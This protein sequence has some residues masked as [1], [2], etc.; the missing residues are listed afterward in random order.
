MNNNKL[1]WD[2]LSLDWKVSLIENLMGDIN[3]D[4]SG[5]DKKELS[6]ELILERFINSNYSI[7]D[8]LNLQSLSINYSLA[9]DLTPVFKLQQ[10]NDFYIEYPNEKEVNYGFTDFIYIYPKQLRAKVKKLDFYI[11]KYIK[12]NLETIKDFVNLREI[13]F[14]NCSI[15]S[16]AGIQNLK[17]LEKVTIDQGNSFNDLSPL[18]ELKLKYLDI[19]FSNVSDLNPLIGMPLET[20]NIKETPIE[21]LSPLMQ[22]PTLQHLDFSN[23]EV[24]YDNLISKYLSNHPS[25]IDI[26]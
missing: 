5:N 7:D 3:S 16:L 23:S 11:P 9:I 20:L 24:D 18:K 6:S 12:G 22:V 17:K 25:L 2:S 10:L 4:Q 14:Q 19:S 13:S 15:S 26:Q 8:I 21:D 1:W